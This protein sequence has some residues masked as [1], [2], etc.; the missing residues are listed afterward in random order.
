MNV[1]YQYKFDFTDIISNYENFVEIVGSKNKKLQRLIMELEKG[2]YSVDEILTDFKNIYND[3]MYEKRICSRIDKFEETQIW[4]PIKNGNV[5]YVIFK[6]F[7]V[8]MK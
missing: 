5:D 7:K 6:K 2:I 8:I 1:R 3:S 4:K